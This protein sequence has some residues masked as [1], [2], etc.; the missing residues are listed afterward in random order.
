MTH[1]TPLTPYT[2]TNNTTPYTQSQ[3]K[4]KFAGFQDDAARTSK[5]PNIGMRYLN[6]DAERSARSARNETAM[7]Y[8]SQDTEN[9]LN[10]RIDRIETELK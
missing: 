5:Q 3:I 7:T 10:Q 2:S 6:L 4:L 1:S 8:L 9:H